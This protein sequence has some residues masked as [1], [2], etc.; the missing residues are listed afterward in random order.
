MGQDREKHRINSHPI[1]HCLTSERCERTSEWSS[2]WPHTPICILGYSGPQCVAIFLHLSIL[3]SPTR[4]EPL[5]WDPPQS[6]ASGFVDDIV[7]DLSLLYVPL[8]PLC[9]YFCLHIVSIMS[10][11]RPSADQCTYII[12][13]RSFIQ[14]TGWLKNSCL[15]E[16]RKSSCAEL[17]CTHIQKCLRSSC[18]KRTAR[19]D[20]F[21]GQNLFYLLK[22]YLSSVILAPKTF[23]I[24]SSILQEG[25]GNRIR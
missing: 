17:G 23:S 10:P 19:R 8:S 16:W 24:F 11:W 9:F 18:H 20:E 13:P 4:T 12:W 5:W 7:S 15:I 14:K 1:I 6:K 3:L 25:R 22:F 2:E 21:H